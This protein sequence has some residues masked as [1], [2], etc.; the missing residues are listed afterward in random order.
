M[1]DTASRAWRVPNS[2]SRNC[3]GSPRCP[4]GDALLHWPHLPGDQ[5]D[6]RLLALGQGRHDRT[7]QLEPRPG[8]QPAG[9]DAPQHCARLALC[10]L[11][12]DGRVDGTMDDAQVAGADELV[13][14]DIVDVAALAQLGAVQHHEDVVTVGA[15]L[16]YGVT[17]DAGPAGQGV[18]A[19]HLRQDPGG[20]LVTDRDV[21]PDQPV[22]AGQQRRQVL[23][24]MLLDAFIGHEVHVHP[25]C[26]L[27]G[28]VL[29]GPVYAAA[30]APAQQPWRS[31]HKI[32]VG[33]GENGQ[34][35]G[36]RP[37][38]LAPRA[39]VCQT[40]GAADSVNPLAGHSESGSRSERRML[41]HVAWGSRMTR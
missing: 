22:I 19:E 39:L 18:E 10:D 23:D 8:A 28:A 20:R 24:R 26:H 5:L 6:E 3:S 14:L 17:L 1:L 29:H 4:G 9:L 12:G 37:A 38:W 11:A 41:R 27:L 25:T 32:V 13:E 15:H 34:R 16:G 36:W 7:G 2:S 31:T 30:T 21:D 40:G 33:L 35:A